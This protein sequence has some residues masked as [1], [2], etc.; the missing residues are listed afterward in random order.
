MPE[1]IDLVMGDEL[2][3]HDLLCQFQILISEGDAAYPTSRERHL[4]RG[5]KYHRSLGMSGS[6][7]LV[8]E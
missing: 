4:A 6:D 2:H 5:G 3:G 1:L 8:K 7:A